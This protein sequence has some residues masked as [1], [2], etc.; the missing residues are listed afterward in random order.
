M[1]LIGVN[2]KHADITRMYLGIAQKPLCFIHTYYSSRKGSRDILDP[3]RGSIDILNMPPNAESVAF[4]QN[5]LAMTNAAEM[6]GSKP[7]SV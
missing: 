5:E 4:Y 6:I 2:D 1:S 7:I 3:R